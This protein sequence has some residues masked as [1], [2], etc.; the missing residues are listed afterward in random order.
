MLLTSSY[1]AMISSMIRGTWALGVQA[2]V[3]FMTVEC[4]Y[5]QDVVVVDSQ[6]SIFEVEILGCAPDLPCACQDK[7]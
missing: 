2:N 1:Q 4:A 7:D 5:A 3:H 6:M